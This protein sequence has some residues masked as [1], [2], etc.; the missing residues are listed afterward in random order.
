[1]QVKV[2]LDQQTGASGSEDEEREGEREKSCQAWQVQ[3]PM[4]RSTNG[5][6]SELRWP[7]DQYTKRLVKVQTLCVPVSLS[8]L[9][10]SHES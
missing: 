1:M 7:L 2:T 10:N 4:H 6:L 9:S 5:W 8:G 3:L